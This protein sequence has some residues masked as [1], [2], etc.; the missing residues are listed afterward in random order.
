MIALQEGSKFSS[1]SSDDAEARINDKP[2]QISHHRVTPSRVSRAWLVG[3]EGIVASSK[4]ISKVS[5]EFRAEE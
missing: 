5:G 4:R 2:L 1:Y 3:A